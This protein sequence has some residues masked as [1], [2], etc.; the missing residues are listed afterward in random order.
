MHRLSSLKP[1]T[2]LKLLNDLNAFRDEEA[3]ALFA[4]AC[5]ADARGR[6]GAA[7]I[8]YP[9]RDDLVR[10]ATAARSVSLSDLAHTPLDGPD[11]AKVVEERRLKAIADVAREIRTPSA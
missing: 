5:E 6:G 4:L 11:R 3:A 2:I 7:A 10:F 9:Q 1:G 8:D